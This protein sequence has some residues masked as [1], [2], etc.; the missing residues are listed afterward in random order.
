[1]IILV[2]LKTLSTEQLLDIWDVLNGWEWHSLL[3]EKPD[4]FDA[5]P[6]SKKKWQFWIKRTKADYVYPVWCAVDGLLSNEQ[7]QGYLRNKVRPYTTP[8]STLYS[9]MMKSGHP[10]SERQM[11]IILGHFSKNPD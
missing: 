9:A 3:G 10:I 11:K 1:M 5:L 2:N 7:K 8:I 6:I 4:N